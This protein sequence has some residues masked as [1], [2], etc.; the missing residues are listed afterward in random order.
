MTTAA[1]TRH[2][3]VETA[4]ELA[5]VFRR[6][7]EEAPE[8][9]AVPP[10]NI[11]DL[12]A[13]GLTRVIQARRNGGL[14]LDLETHLDVMAAVSEGCPSTAWVLGVAHAHSWL[15]SHLPEKAQD[16]IYGADPQQVVAAV[17]GPR[18]RADEVD[19]GYRLSGFWPFGSGVERSDNWV[20]LG[21]HAFDRS[22]QK[23]DEGDFAVAID[24]IEIRDDWHVTGL[25]ATGSCSMVADEV[26]VPRHRFVSLPAVIMGRSPGAV[27]HD[28]WL[29]TAAPVPVLALCIT[30]AAIGAARAALT[31]FKD[32]LTPGKVLAYA[33]VEQLEWSTT[34]RQFA[35]AAMLADEGAMLLYR[36]AQV[37]D[38]HGRE[39]KEM[40]LTTRA[41]CRMDCALGVR[42]C[43]E[44]AEVLH[45]ASGGSGI[46]TAS[47]LGRLH[48][49]LQAMNQH[50]L[51]NLE[52]NQEMYGRV[53]LG[54]PQSTPL[55]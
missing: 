5:A 28:G 27:L 34:H 41:R 17:I 49:D 54:L 50:G 13:S 33:D 39:G 15:I 18:G 11:A 51:L 42:R 26:F 2:E 35:E 9:R 21:A 46:R 14:E 6:R 32:I 23:I 4:R 20:L 10:E 36:T 40:D 53:L 24:D 43:L 12:K 52:V 37:I 1:P 25:Q 22:G 29:H 47:R 44:A 16:E 48:A 8:V 38:E 31:A 19:G 30:G 55:I 3:L 7:A 45:K